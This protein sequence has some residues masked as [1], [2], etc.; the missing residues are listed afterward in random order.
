M[1]EIELH[2]HPTW[3]LEIVEKLRTTFPKIQFI[4]TTHSPYIVQTV[5]E[6]EIIKLGGDLTVEPGGRTLEEVSRL[7]MDVTNTDRSPRYQAMLDTAR[8]YFA[9]VEESGTATPVRREEIQRELVSMLAPFTDNL[10]YT[11]LLERKG[12]VTPES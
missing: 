12:L 9:L 1:D 10:A 3:Q 4:A 6:G 8:R 11:A 7:V 5:R 2:L